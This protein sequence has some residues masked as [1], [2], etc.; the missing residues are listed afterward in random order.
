MRE[1]R[2]IRFTKME[3]AGNDYIFVNCLE[4]GEHHD[5][6]RLSREISDRHYGVG[7]DGLILVMPS[8]TA[9]FK[10]RIFNSD[11]SEG[12][13]CGN[14][15]RC[16]ARLAYEHGLVAKTEM[17]VETRAGLIRPRLEMVDGAVESVT[18]NMGAPSLRPQDVPIVVADG[19]EFAV[20][21][22]VTAGGRRYLVTGVRMGNPNG[23]IFVE[24]LSRVDLPSEGRALE[25]AAAFPRKA[26]IE[27]VQVLSRTRIRMIVYERGSGVTLA[28]GTGASAS[29]VAAAFTGRTDRSA[30][31]DVTGGSLSIEWT[32]D[33]QVLMTGPAVEIAQ[34]VFTRW[35]EV[36]P[37]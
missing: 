37:G 30:K 36:G 25:S 18:V 31:V 6:P 4:E 27:F 12:D 20:D 19:R 1:T 21:V 28:C 15:M 33:G 10:M 29:L 5:W 2:G 9:D 3:G 11:G 14:G 7:S 35:K 17:T 32:P 13:M 16:F 34:G 8:Q 23:V 22:P 26:N 24:D